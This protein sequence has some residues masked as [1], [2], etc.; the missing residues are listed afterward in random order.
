[1]GRSAGSARL[2]GARPHA[3]PGGR[4]DLPDV[5]QPVRAQPRRCRLGRGHVLAALVPSL[6][7][8]CLRRTGRAPA[9]EAG[10]TT[11]EARTCC[12]RTPKGRSWPW[13]RSPPR[14]SADPAE[15]RSSPTG[16]RSASLLPFLPRVLLARA[17]LRV[18]KESAGW[19]NL[20]RPTD[21]IGGPIEAEGVDDREVVDPRRAG[22]RCPGEPAPCPCVT[23]GTSRPTSTPP[24][25]ATSWSR[26]REE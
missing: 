11:W 7:A 19:V 20:W 5:P 6:V 9:R 4:G 3:D 25:W 13:P 24:P 2:G 8:S 21:Y 14:R 16:R 15:W 18:A 1:M 17:V 22:R 10:S 12:R 26:L 23:P